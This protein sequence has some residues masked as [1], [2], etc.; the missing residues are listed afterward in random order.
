DNA[1]GVLTGVE[2]AAHS[3]A[4]F[5]GSSRD[6]LDDDAI[7]DEWLGTPVLTDEGEEAMLDFVPLAGAW[8]QV[9]DHDVDAELVG[10]LL[11]FAFPQPDPRAVAA[12][13]IGG[14]QQPGRVGVTRPPEVEPP[15][16]DAVHREGGRVMVDADTHPPGICGQIIDA[17]G[18]RS[19]EFLDYKV[20]HPDLFRTPLRPILAA[21]AAEIADQFLFLGVDRN[22]WLL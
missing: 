20:V 16:A 14:D 3:E 13:A 7:A 8:R 1:A 21:I 5:G 19:A 17:I 11:Q 6:Q 2:F 4:G 12:A 15:L 18:H 9:A 22:H 10:Q